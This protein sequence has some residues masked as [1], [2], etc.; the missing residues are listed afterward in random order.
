M[1]PS[2]TRAQ[3]RDLA[4]SYLESKKIAAESLQ[5]EGPAKSQQLL[6]TISI[7]AKSKEMEK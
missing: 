5:I 1:D 7:L 2:S 6:S 3:M 4:L